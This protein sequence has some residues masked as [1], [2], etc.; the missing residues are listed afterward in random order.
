M[1]TTSVCFQSNHTGDLNIKATCSNIESSSVQIED[2]YLYDVSSQSGLS[3]FGNVYEINGSGK[4]QASITYDSTE[5]AYKIIST[6]DGLKTIPIT[7]ATGKDQLK[8]TLDMKPTS[9][10]LQYQTGIMCIGTNHSASGVVFGNYSGFY[11]PTFLNNDW[12]NNENLTGS[13]SSGT[14]YNVEMTVNG[15]SVSIVVKNG[16]TTVASTTFDL[17]DKSSTLFNTLTD[18]QYGFA[19]GWKANSTLYSYAKNIKIKSL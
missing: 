13:W 9:T 6:G 5:Q 15:T 10:D 3:H 16:S 2:C 1:F 7:S 18:R 17:T 12:N 11:N 4:N 14:W 8:I 19:I